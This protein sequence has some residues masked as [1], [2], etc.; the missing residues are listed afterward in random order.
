MG[1]ALLSNPDTACDIIRTLSTN[2]SVPGQYRRAFLLFSPSSRLVV[3]AKIR[4][5]ETM[6]ETVTF[7]KR[8]EEAGAAAITGPFPHQS[9]PS[10]FPHLPLSSSSNQ[11]HLIK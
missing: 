9:S 1:A 5:L 3:T 2:L 7:M 10:P 8:L 11:I 6:E 4:V